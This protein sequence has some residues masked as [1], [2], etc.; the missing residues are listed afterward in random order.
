MKPLPTPK[1]IQTPMREFLQT[2]KGRS[3]LTP[4]EKQTILSLR[5][6]RFSIKQIAEMTNR[7]TT[8]VK[9]IIYP[10]YGK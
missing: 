5:L 7:S 9:R 3:R 8:T 2:P 10:S 4:R 6:Q 1:P